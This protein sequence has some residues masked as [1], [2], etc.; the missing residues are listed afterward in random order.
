MVL[1]P[2][3]DGALAFAVIDSAHRELVRAGHLVATEDL[4]HHDAVELAGQR[5]HVLDFESQHREL[6]RQFSGRPVEIDVLFEPI[7]RDFHRGLERPV[8]A[9]I[10][11][12]PARRS[13][14]RAPLCG[15]AAR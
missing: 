2:A 3:H 7:E 12:L 4:R 5:A 15:Y 13:S 8:R 14:S 1:R 11:S 6:L 9:L 10:F